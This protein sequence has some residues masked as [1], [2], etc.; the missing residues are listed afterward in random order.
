MKILTAITAFTILYYIGSS[1]INDKPCDHRHILTSLLSNKWT[2]AGR[3]PMTLPVKASTNHSTLL[4]ILILSGD[5]ELN[6]GPRK[7]NIVYIHVDCVNIRSHGI[8]RAYVAT[9]AVYGTIGHAYN[10][11]QQTTIFC[12]DQMCNG[13]VGSVKA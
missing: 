8:V 10:Y 11:V 5:I 7:N 6:P 4:L 9:T 13:Y 3:R 2:S 12:K 1:I